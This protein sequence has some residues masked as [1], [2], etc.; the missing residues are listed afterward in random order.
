MRANYSL[1]R[2]AADISDLPKDVVFGVPVLTVTGMN[3]LYIENYTNIIE[4]TDSIIRIRI[5]SGQIKV[6]GKN[7]YVEYYNN[8]D[9]KMIGRIDSIEYQH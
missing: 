5:K 2:K 1:K 6:K 7:L 8:S 4:Y 3:E 9:M